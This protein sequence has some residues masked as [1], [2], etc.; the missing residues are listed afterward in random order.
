VAL[1]LK[2]KHDMSAP[3]PGDDAE[4]K[5]YCTYHQLL[6]PPVKANEFLR[7]HYKKMTASTGG[8]G[9]PSPGFFCIP[10]WF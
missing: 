1:T 3:I 5:D 8:G 10:D 2:G 9:S 6:Q 4:L 7:P